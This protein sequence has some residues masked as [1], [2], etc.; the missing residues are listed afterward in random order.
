MKKNIK[1]TDSY[2]QVRCFPKNPDALFALK[3]RKPEHVLPEVLEL[4]ERINQRYGHIKAPVV[5]AE[6]LGLELN[7]HPSTIKEVMEM[8]RNQDVVEECIQGNRK[9]FIIKDNFKR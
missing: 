4:L 3:K 8:L 9:T 2:G 1:F 5:R 6:D 7:V